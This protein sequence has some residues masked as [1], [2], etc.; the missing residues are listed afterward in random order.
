MPEKLDV[1][2][3]SDEELVAQTRHNALGEGMLA[4]IGRR[5]LNASVQLRDA[6]EKTSRRL[7]A[8]TVVLTIYSAALLVAAVG[9]FC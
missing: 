8:L 6:L 2:E 1:F 7:Y 3:M 4:E 5:Q 9:R